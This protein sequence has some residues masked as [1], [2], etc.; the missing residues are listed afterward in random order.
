M[1]ERPLTIAVDFDGTLCYSVWPNLGEPNRKLIDFLLMCKA[2]G[3]RIILWTC[4]AGELLDVAVAWCEEQGLMFDAINENLADIIEFF[5]SDS[6]K[7]CSDIYIDDKNCMPDVDMIKSL[8][9]AK[10]EVI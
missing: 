10:G 5:G 3:H 2:H 9:S 6:R 7:V 1:V 8:M 4:R